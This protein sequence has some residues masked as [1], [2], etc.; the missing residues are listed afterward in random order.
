MNKWLAAGVSV[1]GLLLAVPAAARPP[2]EESVARLMAVQNMEAGLSEL[3]PAMSALMAEQFRN[4]LQRRGY[5]EVQQNAWR[6]TVF[7]LIDQAVQRAIGSPELHREMKAVFAQ[8]V[9]EI[10]SQEEV[11]ALLAFYDSPTGQSLLRKQGR[12]TALI[13]GQVQ[14]LGVR[15][16]E[17]E[18]KRARLQIERAWRQVD[19]DFRTE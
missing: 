18:F 15:Y 1:L 14:S 3:L 9:R 7:P 6:K 19:P 8:A 2:S 11:D 13:A 5:S 17:A 16:T 12:L 4:D 10:Y